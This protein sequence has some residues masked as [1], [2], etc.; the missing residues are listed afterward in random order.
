MQMVYA[1][2]VKFA[3]RGI[4]VAGVRQGT[5]DGDEVAGPDDVTAFHQDFLDDAR[6][7]RLD[8]GL[9]TRLDRIVGDDGLADGGVEGWVVR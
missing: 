2:I 3:V 6:D 9:L 7:L 4:D 8:K 5:D 1:G